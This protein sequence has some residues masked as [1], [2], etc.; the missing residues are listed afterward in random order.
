MES[1]KCFSLFEPAKSSVNHHEQENYASP[2]AVCQLN[3]FK[4]YTSLLTSKLPFL[5]NSDT[6]DLDNA[7]IKSE[8][9]SNASIADPHQTK[10]TI[11]DDQK[12]QFSSLA[13]LLNANFLESDAGKPASLLEQ[14]FLM[15]QAGRPDRRTAARSKATTTSTTRVEG[16]KKRSYTE[17]E[18]SKALQEIQSGPTGHPKGGRSVQD[19]AINVAQQGAQDEQRRRQEE[20]GSAAVARRRTQHGRS[21]RARQDRGCAEQA[22]TAVHRRPH[23]RRA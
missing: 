19:T 10:M 8:T 2:A 16:A 12:P 23:D 20:A 5:N 9:L 15:N 3:Q 21:R 18:L 6:N 14:M 7:S 4:D 1:L 13:S 17:E 11:S 22:R